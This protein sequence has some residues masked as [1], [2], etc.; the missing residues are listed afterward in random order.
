MSGVEAVSRRHVHAAQ[1][2]AVGTLTR[3]TTGV[4]RLRKYDRWMCEHPPIRSTLRNA[5]QPLVIDLGYGSAPWTT[6]EMAERLRRRISPRIQ[7][8]G[9][10]IDPSRV[11]P[12]H[13]DVHF[14]V[15]GFELAGHRPHLV[16]ACNVLRQYAEDDVEHAWG[17]MRERLAPGGHIVEGTC[18]EN[19]QRATWV[20]LDADGPVSITL[21]WS[22]TAV[23]R[24]S[25]VAERL[26]KS[27]IHRNV[28]GEPIYDL[29]QAADAAWATTASYCAFGPRDRW[30]RTLELLRSQGWPVPYPVRHLYDCRLTVP[31]EAVKPR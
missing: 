11:F 20:L 16:R 1:K 18:S 28:P 17:M 22:P 31:W 9:L 10:E 5:H 8:I 4:N 15:G 7:V 19:G 25:D 30:R 14:A 2:G 29:L 21:A 24:P 26:P 13:N 12:P 27:L 3:G 23:A 6:V